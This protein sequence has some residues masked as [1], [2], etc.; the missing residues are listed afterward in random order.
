MDQSITDRAQMKKDDGASVKSGSN[1]DILS[2]TSKLSAAVE[3]QTDTQQNAGNDKKQDMNASDQFQTFIDNMVNSSQKVQTD[4]NRNMAQVTELRD[5]ANQIID[6]I[7]VSVTQDKTS[8]ELSLNPDHLGKVN[9]SVQSKDG[10]M[11]AHFIVQNEISKE[12]IESQIHTL[13]DTLNNQGIKVEAIEVTVSANAFE[14]NGNQNSEN[15]SEEQ[16]N[17]SGRK[18]SFDDA[19]NMTEET[20]AENEAQD[21]SGALGSVVDYTA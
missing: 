3:K 8:M 5:I 9:L 6:K 2:D 7:K 13:R 14:Q 17:H 20:E 16:K 4:F 12:A 19:V 11:T 21:L 15:Q 18:I 1:K 10:I